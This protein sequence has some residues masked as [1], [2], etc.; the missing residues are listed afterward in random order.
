ML[1]VNCDV[2]LVWDSNFVKYLPFKFIK[3]GVIFLLK[4]HWKSFKMFVSLVSKHFHPL[5]DC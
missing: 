1:G 4:K 5:Y 2:F 3:G